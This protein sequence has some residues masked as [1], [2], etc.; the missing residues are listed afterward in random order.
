MNCS[1]ILQSKQNTPEVLSVFHD[2]NTAAPAYSGMLAGAD[3]ESALF[4]C[5]SQAGKYDGYLLDFIKN[6]AQIRTDTRFEQSRARLF[7]HYKQAHMPIIPGQNIKESFFH[8]VQRH[9]FTLAVTPCNPH[10][11]PL[12]AFLREYDQDRE[13]L[14]LTLLNEYGD[15]TGDMDVPLREI[16]YISSERETERTAR[17]L[18]LLG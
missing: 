12:I 14:L 6:I 1:D 13:R 7:K 11:A 3:E 8:F 10:A 18:H 9:K 4:Y 16:K 15:I 17:N 2:T 5:V